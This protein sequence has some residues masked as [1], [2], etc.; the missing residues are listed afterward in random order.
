MPV[1]YQEKG[2]ILATCLESKKDM[3]ERGEARAAVVSF[4]SPY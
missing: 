4:A 1:A 2:H 3:M